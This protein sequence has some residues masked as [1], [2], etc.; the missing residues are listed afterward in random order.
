M[1]ALQD[2]NSIY[3][4]EETIFFNRFVRERKWDRKQAK[5]GKENKQDKTKANT[6]RQGEILFN[7]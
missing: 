6:T 7:D 5:V 2:F 3:S 1:Q 4:R